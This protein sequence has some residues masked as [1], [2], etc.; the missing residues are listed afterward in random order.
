MFVV[1]KNLLRRVSLSRVDSAGKVQV[2][3]LGGQP[4]EAERFLPWGLATRPA[5]GGKALVVFVGASQSTPVVLGEEVKDTPALAT[6]EVMI[7]AQ[8]GAQVHLKASGDVLV[9]PGAGGKV[10]IGGKALP[11]IAGI[12]TG[13]C[14]CA[15]TGSPH[16][17]FS[18]TV[19][20]KKEA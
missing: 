7:Y 12:V 13:Q 18:Q 19:L 1:L 6:G 8:G 3:G 2:Q 15:F 17:E 11:P 4:L 14:V 10:E 5:A 9:L 16:P 20:A